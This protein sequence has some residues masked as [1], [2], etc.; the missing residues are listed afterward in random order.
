M[1]TQSFDFLQKI[2]EWKNVAPIIVS[3]F[4]WKFFQIFIMTQS[5]EF[6]QEIGNGNIILLV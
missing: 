6:L 2:K 1:V 5:F 3:S 4:L